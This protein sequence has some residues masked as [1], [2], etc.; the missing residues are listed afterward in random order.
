MRFFPLAAVKIAVCR[1]YPRYQ[2]NTGVTVLSK[3]SVMEVVVP[4]KSKN[5]STYT[6]KVQNH[7][8]IILKSE[9]AALQATVL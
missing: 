3:Q 6:S 4:F 1:K 5:N 8:I 9:L 7:S 2:L